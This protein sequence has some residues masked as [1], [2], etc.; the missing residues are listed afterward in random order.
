MI[1]LFKKLVNR[2]IGELFITV[3]MVD[4]GVSMSGIF[5][6]VYFY[7]LGYSLSKIALYYALVYTFYLFLIPVGAHIASRRGFEH[8]ILYSM[9]FTIISLLLLFGLS[10][11]PFL[12]YLIP[13]VRAIDKSLYWPAYYTDFA[14]YTREGQRGREVSTVMTISAVFSS[15][16]PIIGGLI[17]SI[18]G[19]KILF[20]AVSIILICSA[21]PLFTT[22]EIFTPKD[23]GYKKAFRRL[24]QKENRLP[25]FGFMG[26]AE[27][28]VIE[29]FWPIFV[30]IV[31][32][33]YV[34]LGAVTSIATFIGV[35]SLIVFGHLSDKKDRFKLIHI[36]TWP[37]AALYIVRIFAQNVGSVLGINI[38]SAFIVPGINIPLTSIVYEVGRD[39][40]SH[41][42]YVVFFEMS[43]IISKMILSWLLVFIFLF[44]ENII[45]AFII[46]SLF[47]LLYLFIRRTSFVNRGENNGI[48][49]A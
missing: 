26:T 16:G 41:L 4:F 24:Y 10:E 45:I 17:V 33:G 29:A 1:N 49:L 18:F 27:A 14:H 31:V 30:F 19:F 9:P 35:A 46:A 5:V 12:F 47:T 23:F 22:R 3:A 44:K 20:V 34:S 36:F 15:L 13:L 28:L 25:F 42:R 39:I 2:E 7:S 32:K 6:P 8:S 11:Y 37:L 38:F 43:L 48:D 21:I 40:G